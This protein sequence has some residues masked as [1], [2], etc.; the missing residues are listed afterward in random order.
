MRNLYPDIVP[1][2]P[3]VGDIIQTS[4]SG[5]VTYA[6]VT[7]VLDNHTFV[8][9]SCDITGLKLSEKH[10]R[11]YSAYT[12]NI[13]DKRYAPISDKPYVCSNGVNVIV[14]GH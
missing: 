9:E 8:C 5:V 1:V 14:N 12:W 2:M 4:Y 6:I 7:N 13:Y 3:K 10:G 11:Y